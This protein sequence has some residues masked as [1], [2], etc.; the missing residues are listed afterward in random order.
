MNTLY[1]ILIIA[2]PA[3]TG[4][5]ITLGLTSRRIAKRDE[6]LKAARLYIT[7]EALPTKTKAIEMIDAA[8]IA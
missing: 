8:L 2:G 6:A 4:A 3:I 5:W 7:G 1:L